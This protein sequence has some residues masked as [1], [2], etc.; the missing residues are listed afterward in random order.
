MNVARF[1]KWHKGTVIIYEKNERVFLV[2]QMIPHVSE[3]F[4]TLFAM[5]FKN[6]KKMAGGKFDDCA[7]PDY[8]FPVIE[9]RSRLYRDPA[10]KDCRIVAGIDRPLHKVEIPCGVKQTSSP[11]R[12]PERRSG[13]SEPCV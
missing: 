5:N 7:F 9:A 8:A 12:K 2:S 4:A 10:M 1:F 13:L 11:K 6:L 3:V